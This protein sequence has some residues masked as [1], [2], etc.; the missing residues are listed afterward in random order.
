MPGECATLTDAIF[1][2]T[3]T[4]SARSAPCRHRR[5]ATRCCCARTAHYGFAVCHV[6]PGTEAGNGVCLHQV[7]RRR[8]KAQ[9]SGEQFVRLLDLCERFA[10]SAG[11]PN[12]SP[13]S[14]PPARGFLP[15]LARARLPHLRG[16]S[17]CSGPTPRV[18][19]GPA[20]GVVDDW[21]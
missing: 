14:T 18:S 9:P 16:A 11:R 1:P 13:T 4:W 7:R 2:D 19:T 15:R 5:S 3:S 17:P 8:A 10:A 12:W 6:G 21:R 20:H